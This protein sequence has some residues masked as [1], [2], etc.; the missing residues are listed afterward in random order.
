MRGRFGLRRSTRCKTRV[1][2]LT[3]VHPHHAENRQDAALHVDSPQGVLTSHATFVG[4][5]GVE[6]I[7]GPQVRIVAVCEL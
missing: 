1:S 5:I 2:N 3:A 6:P 4:E 7:F